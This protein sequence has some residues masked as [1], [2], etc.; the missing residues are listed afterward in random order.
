MLSF[1]PDGRACLTK[2]ESRGAILN[3]GARE[4]ERTARRRLIVVNFR[5]HERHCRDDLLLRT[6]REMNGAIAAD[7]SRVMP[8]YK[9][10]ARRRDNNTA[11]ERCD[12][13]FAECEV[14]CEAR[15]CQRNK[16]EQARRTGNCGDRSPVRKAITF[17]RQAAC[18]TTE[19]AESHRDWSLPKRFA[20]IGNT[21]RRRRLV[22]V[23]S[24]EQCRRVH[25]GSQM[26]VHRR[27]V[28]R[29]QKTGDLRMLRSGDNG[30]QTTVPDAFLPNYWANCLLIR[31]RLL[32]LW[33]AEVRLPGAQWLPE[34]PC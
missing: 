23:K 24:N 15:R 5:R 25:A 18:A 4:S 20:F 30:L 33:I 21:T 13:G 1:V 19:A 28:R 22:S 10:G 8:A 12:S 17:A 9:G 29:R 26:F 3:V 7:E 34:C 27:E 16:D 32:A 14:W 31:H 11:I 2:G 6:R